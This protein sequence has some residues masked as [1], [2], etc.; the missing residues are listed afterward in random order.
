MAHGEL[1]QA[2]QSRAEEREHKL[3]SCQALPTDQSPPG[4]RFIGFHREGGVGGAPD[5]WFRERARRGEERE[6]EGSVAS[7]AAHGV[8]VLNSLNMVGT[9]SQN[10][11][12]NTGKF[13]HLP[14]TPPQPTH[15]SKVQLWSNIRMR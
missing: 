1:A 3:Q 8:P 2:S 12:S 15:L 6:A 9:V 7:F 14:S 4:N 5:Y 10:L 11:C 13:L